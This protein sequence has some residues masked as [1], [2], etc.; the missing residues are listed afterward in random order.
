MAADG[1]DG[2]P[3]LGDVEAVLRQAWGWLARPGAVVIEVAPDQ[4]RRPSAWLESIGYLDVDVVADLAGRPR[5]LVG[6]V[7]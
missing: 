4:A 2:T 6:R 1:T 3:G 5:A 7:R